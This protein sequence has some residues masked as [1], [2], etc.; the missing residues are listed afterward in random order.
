MNGRKK[1][2]A[3]LRAEEIRR[4]PPTK[5]QKRNQMSI[6]LINMAGNKHSQLKSKSYDEIQKL[7]DKE[8]KRVNTFVDMNSE[9][10]KEEEEMKKHM[11][12]VQDEQ[13]IAIDAI[14]QATKPPMI[15][16]YN[17]V[18]KGQKGFYH[19]IRAGGSLKR[20]SSMI[21]MLQGIDREDLETLWKLVKEKSLNKR[22]V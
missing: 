1:H 22:L 17:I 15:V 21:R 20:Y 14:P 8:M 4:N 7:F 9:V 6:Y 19:L 12:I 11:E 2:F 16:E 18:K 5:S 13:E 10:V 3:K